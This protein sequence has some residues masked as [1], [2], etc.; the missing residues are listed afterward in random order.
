MSSI[1]SFLSIVHHWSKLIGH[2]DQPAYQQA[3]VDS[4]EERARLERLN[5]RF[6]ELLR[7]KE[8]RL[9]GQVDRFVARCA[10]DRRIAANADFLRMASD[11]RARVFERTITG[12]SHIIRDQVPAD[13]RPDARRLT[14]D[15]ADALGSAR[16]EAKG[17][18][19]FKIQ[20]AARFAAKNLAGMKPDLAA[21][22][23]EHLAA[24][25][26]QGELE[27]PRL[28]KTGASGQTD[29][30]EWQ[31]AELAVE[32]EREPVRREPFPEEVQNPLMIWLGDRRDLY[33]QEIR[34][35][36]GHRPDLQLWTEAAHLVRNA[37][38]SIN[39]EIVAEVRQFLELCVAYSKLDAKL[40]AHEVALTVFHVLAW[41]LESVRSRHHHLAKLVAAAAPPE[42]LEHVL[43]RKPALV[44]S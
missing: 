30:Y 27:L 39:P 15:W 10:A 5:R 14:V 4:R 9:R 34:E 40:V 26:R 20:N 21:L 23:A 6:S 29:T 18:G 41:E 32:P 2:A 8:G 13:E 16:W 37:A 31:S 17:A 7:E 35:L 36:H 42:M 1:V 24:A 44:T 33:D 43:R 25:M 3:V 38:T 19:E 11:S 28:K 22:V 12:S